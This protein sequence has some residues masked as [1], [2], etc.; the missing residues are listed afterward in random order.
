M[1]CAQWRVRR[2]CAGSEEQGRSS[3]R[4]DS[5]ADR[6]PAPRSKA[7]QW[8]VRNGACADRVPAPRS[9]A[10]QVSA[11]TLKLTVKITTLMTH[12]A[13]VSLRDSPSLRKLRPSRAPSTGEGASDTHG[14]PRA[15]GRQINSSLPV[16]TAEAPHTNTSVGRQSHWTSGNHTRTAPDPLHGYQTA[17]LLGGRPGTGRNSRRWHEPGCEKL[18]KPRRNSPAR[19]LKIALDPGGNHIHHK[20]SVAGL[21]PDEQMNALTTSCNGTLR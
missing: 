21:P 19:W 18:A 2:P 7:G 9:K 16:R 6:V 3:L 1:A 8:R 15:P 10:G 12:S 13:G 20:G 17:H 14:P 5:K 4:F 11:L